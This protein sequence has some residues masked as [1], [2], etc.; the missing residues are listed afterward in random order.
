MRYISKILFTLPLFT[1]TACSDEQ[2]IFLEN[3]PNN[4][5]LETVHI[6]HRD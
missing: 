5:A 6:D 2:D 3:I 4:D 1:V